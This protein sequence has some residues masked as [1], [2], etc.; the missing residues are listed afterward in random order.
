MRPLSDSEVERLLTGEARSGLPLVRQILIYLDPFA[1]FK[2]ASHG[3]AQARALALSYNRAMRWMLLRYLRRWAAIAASLFLLIA[4]TEAAAAH[5]AVFVI[6][7]AAVAAGFCI[8]VAVTVCTAAVYL[9]LGNK[10]T[11]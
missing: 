4:P 11:W 5:E 8:A 3:P 2:D 9:L 7:M 1:L 10:T 6:P